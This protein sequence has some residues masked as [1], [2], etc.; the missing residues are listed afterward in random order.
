MTLENIRLIKP[1]MT[2]EHPLRIIFP[3]RRSSHSVGKPHN[4][5]GNADRS[6]FIEKQ[7]VKEKAGDNH[8]MILLPNV[9]NRRSYFEASLKSRNHRCRHKKKRGRGRVRKNLFQNHR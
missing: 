4:Q 6:M 2:A 8:L 9:T 5:A 7:D 1:V 3:K